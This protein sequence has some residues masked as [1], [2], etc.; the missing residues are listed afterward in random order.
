MNLQV[1]GDNGEALAFY[2]AIGYRVDDAVS[3]GEERL[4][5]DRLPDGP[6]SAGRSHRRLR[7]SMSAR[8]DE[9]CEEGASPA[10]PQKRAT[11]RDSPP[12]DLLLP[13]PKLRPSSPPQQH[14]LGGHPSGGRQLVGRRPRPV[15]WTA[16]SRLFSRSRDPAPGLRV[17]GVPWGA[18]GVVERVIEG[19]DT[20]ALMPTGGGKSLCYQIPALVRPAPAW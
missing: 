8:S 15:R 18:G 11:P 7:T 4:I 12:G 5:D 13:R 2:A 1:R 19:G 17:R 16:W 3:S 10:S 9:S 6:T 14:A 20:L